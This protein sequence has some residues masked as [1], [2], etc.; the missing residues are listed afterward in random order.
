MATYY[1][2]YIGGSDANAGTLIAPWQHCHGDPNATGNAASY[3]PVAGDTFIFKGGIQYSGILVLSNSGSAGNPISYDGNS[4][5]T[6]GT[7]QA[8][9]DAGGVASAIFDLGGVSYVTLNYLE[10]RH[11]TGL[12]GAIW[13]HSGSTHIVVS[14]CKIHNTGLEPHAT[15][16]GMAININTGSYW[17]IHHNLIYDCYTIGIELQPASYCSIHDNEIT[18]IVI[19]G[20]RLCNTGSG[21]RGD[22]VG[23][24]IYNNTLHDIY[25]Y[26]D[27]V[28]N[29]G[30]VIHID[31]I[32]VNPNYSGYTISNTAIYNNKFYNNVDFGGVY[33][34][35]S[36]LT[37]ET[38]LGATLSNLDIY[39]NIFFNPESV[40][41][42]EMYAGN[43]A[44]TGIRIYG[45]SIWTSFVAFRLKTTGVA[46][47]ITI[48]NNIVYGGEYQVDT[49]SDLTLVADHNCYYP[50]SGSGFVTNTGETFA[51]WQARGYDVVGSFVADPKFASIIIGSE[52]LALQVSSPCVDAGI[53]LGSPYN[54][55]ILG[56]SR[57]KGA[58]YDMGAYEYSGNQKVMILK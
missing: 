10:I 12:N 11:N 31:F 24:N 41:A 52:N 5:G 28:Y 4:T 20:I 29:P 56:A 9:I 16:C 44:A 21:G 6:F 23:N 2:D 45:N 47:E 38:D 43:A 30:Y 40:I 35:T 51:Q 57:P 7:G 26:G 34:G 27:P 8:I 32:F 17:E 25:H 48:R 49:Y 1:I 46:M 42:L 13:D 53:S 14:Y 19:W 22:C 15:C 3:T 55:D 58:G 50:V 18:D 33:S 39:N 37:M 54:V 36:M